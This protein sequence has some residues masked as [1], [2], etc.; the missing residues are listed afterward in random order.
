MGDL[1]WNRNSLSHTFICL[2]A[3][4]LSLISAHADP[5]DNWS[6]SHMVTNS[7]AFNGFSITS[8]AY[9]SGRFVAVGEYT[10]SDFGIIQTSDDGVQWAVRSA[11]DGSVLDLYDVTFGNGLF[12]AVGW[13]Y[14]NGQNIYTSTNGVNWVKH[15]TTISNLHGVTYGGGLFVAVGD[16]ELINGT[17]YTSYNIYISNDGAVWA[18]ADSGTPTN[19]L[20]DVAYGAGKYIAVDGAHHLYS[21]SNGSSWSRTTNSLA[22][23]ALA[24]ATVSFCNGL[25]F[26]P[27]GPGTNLIS[28]DG[29]NWS[30]TTNNT[31]SVFQHVIDLH[32]T[33]LAL[34]N[35]KIFS[36]T[37]G[38]NWVRRN[39]NCPT[40][41][42]MSDFA[43]GSRNLVVAGFTNSPTKF[44]DLPSAFV[45]DPFVALTISPTVPPQL[46]LSGLTNRNF[47]IEVA[48]NLL[49]TNWQV[50][51]NLTLTNGP[52]SLTDTQATNS[53]RF[54]RAIL[55]P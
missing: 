46:T 43:L 23:A 25:F 37:D 16:G 47:S 2:F 40:N 32:G 35:S 17:T 39:F 34:A 6:P 31:A 19:T 12:V 28:S 29:V 42:S 26:V 44:L 45:S 5:L 7:P 50:L 49:S 21:S 11:Y 48:T 15:V 24:P 33:F 22:G 14:Y 8:L 3:A 54:Y 20:Y 51:T 38:T 36:S 41:T 18:P 9:G 10:G 53:C 1:T 30:A 13:D 4:A 52:T 55:L 27:S